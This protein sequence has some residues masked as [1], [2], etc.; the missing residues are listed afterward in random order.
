MDL[1]QISY[2]FFLLVEIMPPS[3]RVDIILSLQNDHVLISPNEP[4]CLLSIEAPCAWEQSSIILIFFLFANFF[5][6]FMSQGN[7]AK[8]TQ[9]IALVF[10]VIFFL[11]SSI[12]IF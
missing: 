2:N 6:L 3:P 11:I 7:P 12:K 10:L 8:C 5:I 1:L 4:T 9:I